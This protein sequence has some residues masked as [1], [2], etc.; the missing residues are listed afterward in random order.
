VPHPE[1]GLPVVGMVGAGQLARM[2]QQAAI[3]LGLAIRV[4]ADTPTDSAA[5]VC[6]DVTIGDYR[7]YAD[8]AAFAAGCDVVTFDHEHVP[9]AH[10]EKLVAAGV[11]VHPGPQSLPFVQNKISM[12]R[13]L[14][15][16]AI[17]VPAWAVVGDATGIDAFATSHGWPVVAKAASGGYDGRGVWVLASSAEAVDV[18][19]HAARSGVRLY[20][21]E[22]VD[23][24]RELAVLVARSTSG[25]IAGW[26]TVQT[27]QVDGICVEVIAPAPD[28]S[29]AL[30]ADARALA[31]HI[32]TE[33]DVVGL[34]A[35]ELFDTDR[36][37]VVNELAMRPHNCG[38]WTIDG[39]V[40]S[41]FE[42]HL[43]AVIGWPLGETSPLAPVTVMT[44][45][46][47]G[48]GPGPAAADIADRIPAVF[49]DDPGVHLHLYGKGVRPGR[50]LG[51][52][53]VLGNDLAQTRGRAEEAVDG[54]RGD[55]G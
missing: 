26:P 19:A 33:L 4:L 7:D 35:V 47:G 18:A 48:S 17:A 3:S 5:L 45:L 40:T 16:L 25:E 49:A 11:V 30:D 43:R 36:G 1:T 44:N 52:V 34:L 22:H 24:R 13:R 39:S 8:L 51:H 50:K 12:R 27:V 55:A 14:T 20:V 9:L 38:H 2:T 10:V 41:Q 31:A 42:Q 53:N 37:L 32:A 29:D 54:L 15:E 6:R 46:L 23:F 28:L 21:E